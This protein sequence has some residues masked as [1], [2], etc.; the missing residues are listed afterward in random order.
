MTS[1]R[2]GLRKFRGVRRRPPVP[3]VRCSGYSARCLEVG[4]HMPPCRCV[5]PAGH[6]GPCSS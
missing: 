5:E 1:K 2:V 3:V 4:E 6:L